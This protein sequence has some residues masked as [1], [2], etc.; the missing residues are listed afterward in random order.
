MMRACILEGS[1]AYAAT[2]TEET[3]LLIG[4]NG[5]A[6]LESGTGEKHQRVKT[7][8]L[9]CENMPRRQTTIMAAVNSAWTPQRSD[10]HNHRGNGATGCDEAA[11]TQAK[12]IQTR[13]GRI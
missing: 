8:G 6:N 13:C 11:R 10:D 5:H 3:R 12:P 7:G 1:E 4:G 9:H 2:A